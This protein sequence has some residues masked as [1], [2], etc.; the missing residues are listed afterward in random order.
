MFSLF[1]NLKFFLFA[2]NRKIC[3]LLFDLFICLSF[4]LFLIELILLFS[5]FIKLF[6]WFLSFLSGPFHINIVI[7]NFGYFIVFCHLFF[8]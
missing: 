2:F 6:S 4:H 3:H 5:I 8:T 7:L 1:F